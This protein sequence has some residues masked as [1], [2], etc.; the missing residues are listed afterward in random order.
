MDPKSSKI[1]Y[2]L[3]YTHIMY[4]LYPALPP[5]EAEGNT[6]IYEQETKQQYKSIIK[7]ISIKHSIKQFQQQ[8][9]TIPKLPTLSLFQSDTQNDSEVSEILTCILISRS[10]MASNETMKN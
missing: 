4:T 3:I 8:Q 7:N 10:V 5:I 6:T 9:N 1:H 2:L